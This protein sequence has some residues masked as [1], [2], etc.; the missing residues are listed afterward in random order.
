[1]LCVFR[2]PYWKATVQRARHDGQGGIHYLLEPEYHGNPIAAEGSLVV[3]EWG[4]DLCDVIFRASGMT[5]TAIRICDRY[6][7]IQGEFIEVFI[8]RKGVRPERG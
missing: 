2:L 3:T 5:T 6:R 8:S 1:M 4:Y 7:G